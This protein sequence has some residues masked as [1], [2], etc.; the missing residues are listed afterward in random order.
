MPGE[1]V[2]RP[3][4]AGDLVDATRIYRLA[5]GT[6]LGAPDPT[7]FRLDIRTLETRFATDP[8]TAF[9]A[10]RQGRL[11]GSVIGMDWGSQFVV[12]PLTVDPVCWGQGVARL[13]TA[14]ILDAAVERKP[15][16]VS[17]FTHPASTTHLRLYESVGFVPMYLTPIL[18]K[19]AG[20]AAP[21]RVARLFSALTVPE[22]A[23]ALGQSRNLTDAIFAGLDLRREIQSIEDQH[24]GETILLDGPDAL[25]GVA[26]CHIG[27]GTE[28]GEG[29]LFVKFAAVR[30]GAAAEYERLL[31]A[32]DALAAK[33]GVQR[34]SAGVNTGRRDAYRRVLSRGFCAVTTGVAMHRP[35]GPG[36]L[37]PD[38]YI[39]DDWR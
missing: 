10:E 21:V 37:R 34:V 3:M 39:I 29:V 32:I 24:L 7:Q 8:G 31:D 38:V 9:V 13:L 25:A 12:G 33:R 15:A 6:L 27:A 28:A 4:A 2:V 23:I 36:T 22:R 11:L 1:I 16:L 19:P 30:P 5:F 35:D 26:L 18:S 20:S 17:L 14:A